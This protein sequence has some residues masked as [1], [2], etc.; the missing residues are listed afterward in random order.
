MKLDAEQLAWAKEV[1]AYMH[2]Q[3]EPALSQGAYCFW[4]GLVDN[5]WS[6]Q[7][8]GWRSPVTKDLVVQVLQSWVQASE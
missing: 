2:S 3:G 6:T 7:P 4:R 1:L 5:L 8:A